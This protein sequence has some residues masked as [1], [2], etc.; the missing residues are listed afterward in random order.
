MLVEALDPEKD[1]A[2]PASGEPPAIH[3]VVYKHG[4]NRVE[5]NGPDS[6]I[7]R[8]TLESPFK[9]IE[10][11]S[12]KIL[13][14]FWVIVHEGNWLISGGRATGLGGILDRFDEVQTND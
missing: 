2:F 8:E 7:N 14:N 4:E 10:V 1:L 13:S 11:K 9:I 5:M 3:L 6:V 12:V